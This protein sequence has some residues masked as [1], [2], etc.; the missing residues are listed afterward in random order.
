MIERNVFKLKADPTAAQPWRVKAFANA[1]I[2]KLISA[3]PLTNSVPVPGGN[4]PELVRVFV[5]DQYMLR[6]RQEV[7]RVDYNLSSKWR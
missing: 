6:K 2:L 5:Q 3:L 7:V 4:N 1:D